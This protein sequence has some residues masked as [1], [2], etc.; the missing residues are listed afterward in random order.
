MRQVLR[1]AAYGVIT[2]RHGRRAR[3]VEPVERAGLDLVDLVP[4]ALRMTGL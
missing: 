2:D 1:V 4:T 3:W